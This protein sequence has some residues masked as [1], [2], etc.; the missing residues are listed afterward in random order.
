MVLFEGTRR[1]HQ[2]THALLRPVEAPLQLV[3]EPEVRVLKRAASLLNL[4]LLWF[5]KSLVHLV[6]VTFYH[7]QLALEL[8]IVAVL[9]LRKDV[10]FLHTR[11][12]VAEPPLSETVVSLVINPQ[13]VVKCSLVRRRS[14]WD[15]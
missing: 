11:C 8:G 7:A 5:G 14:V 1:L 13:V 12:R 15:S 10:V 2:R 4:N 6:L 3:L 9:A